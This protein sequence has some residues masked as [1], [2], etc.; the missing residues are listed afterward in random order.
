MVALS[1]A[2]NAGLLLVG[3]GVYDPLASPQQSATDQYNVVRFLGGQGPYVQREG[4]GISTEI[5]SQCTIE[6]VQL[7][8]RHGER[9]PSKGLGSNLNSTYN[10][11]AQL[12]GSLKGD[13]AL[14]NTEP[15]FVQDSYWYDRET[16]PN[17]AADIFSGTSNAQRHGSYFRAR[18]NSLFDEK[19]VL[20]VFT[21]NSQRCYQ[22][23]NYFARG[24]LGDSYSD[25]TAQM[26]VISEDATQGGN[27][28]TPRY[29]CNNYNSSLNDAKVA[30]FND[31]FLGDIIT[32][33]KND[34]PDLNITKTDVSN[35]FAYVAYEMNVKGY[36]KVANLFTNDE[37]IK[38]SYKYDLS[39]YY[40]NGPGNNLTISIGGDMALA[41]L[42]LLKD[43]D[44]EQKV[45]LSFT[46]DTDV[47]I[48]HAALGLVEPTSDL[49]IDHIVFPSTYSHASIVPQGARVYVEKLKCSGEEYVRF[50]VNDAV[51]PVPALGTGPGFSTKLSDYEIYLND[52]LADFNYVK[53]C[54]VESDVPSNIT[55][56]WDYETN[57]F[58]NGTTKYNAPLF[59]G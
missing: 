48:M 2:M 36:S 24:F 32:R 55:F 40:T 21:S 17:N 39:Q 15:Y 9:Y 33:W 37:Y 11:I 50:I 53:T 59:I 51:V 28:L 25:K 30:K 42:E 46:H 1:K 56:Y 14:F 49:P 58:P 22:T 16:S 41:S 10:K 44:N 31:S 23:A 7:F 26:Y 43:S 6:Q 52:R 47:E 5:P 20:P 38:Y 18:Y 29:A 19:S 3:Q 8:S 45:W 12:K 13:L 35:L 4:S 57:L 34:N 27:S 54:G